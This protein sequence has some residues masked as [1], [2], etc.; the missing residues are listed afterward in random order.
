[1]EEAGERAGPLVRRVDKAPTSLMGEILVQ[2]G[3]GVGAGLATMR[4]Q[5]C[6]Q[7]QREADRQGGK[8]ATTKAAEPGPEVGAV[9]MAGGGGG[10][11]GVKE[12]G[13]PPVQHKAWEAPRLRALNGVPGVEPQP[14]ELLL[15][16]V[17]ACAPFGTMEN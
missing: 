2:R 8:P 10:W 7:R 9:P 17:W 16:A 14:R 3:Q 15:G 1:M 6:K 13:L 4:K 12:M 5:T 11:G